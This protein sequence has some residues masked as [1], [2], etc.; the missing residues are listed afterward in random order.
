LTNFSHSVV[1]RQYTEE[2]F[3]PSFVP[4]FG[5]ILL[6]GCP[7]DF[8]I[9]PLCSYLRGDLVYDVGWC[10]HHIIPAFRLWGLNLGHRP[11]LAEEF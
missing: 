7:I 2:F 5:H 6:I 8:I 4:Y 9:P 10:V 3:S 11:V 1:S